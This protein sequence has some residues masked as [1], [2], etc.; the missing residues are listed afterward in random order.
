MNNVSLKDQIEE[1]IVLIKDFKNDVLVKE[2]LKSWNDDLNLIKQ[3]I[4]N[5]DLSNK[6]FYEIEQISSEVISSL[7]LKWVIPHQKLEKLLNIL[8]LKN[9]LFK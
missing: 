9:N 1:I 3:K 6:D 8:T 4:V 2:F 7:I 5:K